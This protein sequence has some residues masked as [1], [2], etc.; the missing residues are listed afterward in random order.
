MVDLFYLLG[1]AFFHNLENYCCSLFE[2]YS[3]TKHLHV[4]YKSDQPNGLS[5][6]VPSEAFITTIYKHI[7]FVWFIFLHI[8]CNALYENMYNAT[9]EVVV[10]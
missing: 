9:F 1:I 5:E 10:E 2:I 3:S 4:S 6:T 7:K 8:L